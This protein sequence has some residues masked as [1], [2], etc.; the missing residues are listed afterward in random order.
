MSKGIGRKMQVG[1]A[2]ETSRGTAE[3][4]ATYWAPFSEAEINEKDEKA[5]VDMSYGLIEESQ[6]EEIVKQW[7]EATVKAPVTDKHFGLLLLAA[8]GSVSTGDNAD[9]DSS[10][11]DHT[12]SVAQSAQHQALT[13]F[14]DDPLGGQD[15][16]HAM[17]VLSSLELNYER[18]KF[19]EYSANF[20][21]KKG[22]TASLSPATTTEYRFLPQHLSFKL[23]SDIS[24]L[25]GASAISI[26]SLKLTI[27]KNVE[28]DDV[29]GSV[30]PAD[31]LNK[32]FTITGELE[33]IWQNESD[34]KTAA[35]AG[36]AKAMRIDLVNSGVTI[37]NAANPRLKIDL[38]KVVFGEFA[39]PIKINDVMVQS[40][41]FKAHYS[42]GDTKMVEALMTN[43]VASY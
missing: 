3:S 28:S 1:I 24:G 21:A 19:I 39:N 9:S 43:T 36:T 13:L 16:K 18:G 34:F 22:Q 8:L 10:V 23:A 11:K 40:L 33:A 32:S 38:A 25:D 6:G 4:A 2:K 5:L 30:A 29:L 14:L 37:G 31:F 7:A 27:E 42:T 17:G 20:M 12:F 41:S 15:Y 26:K 35:L